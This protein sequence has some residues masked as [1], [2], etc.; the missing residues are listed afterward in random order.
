[1]NICRERNNEIT[2]P[3]ARWPNVMLAIRIHAISNDLSE[4]RDAAWSSTGKTIWYEE[5]SSQ[6]LKNAVNK[7]KKENHRQSWT[8]PCFPTVK[9]TALLI[10]VNDR[11]ITTHLKWKTLQIRFGI[12]EKRQFWTDGM[13]AA[14]TT[15]FAKT[16]T[17]DRN[18]AA[19]TSSEK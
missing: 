2:V 11:I 12:V 10:N 17:D 14:F 16:R 9:T 4:S 1:M 8:N 5:N 15:W 19:S 6:N 3:R 7:S 18:N 13:A